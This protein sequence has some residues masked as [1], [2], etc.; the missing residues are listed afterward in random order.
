M[1]FC[2][3][4]T[5]LGTW[6]YSH[7][8]FHAV[9]LPLSAL[10]SK[11]VTVTQWVLYILIKCPPEPGPAQGIRNLLG[12]ADGPLMSTGSPLGGSDGDQSLMQICNTG[13]IAGKPTSL[14]SNSSV[15]DLTFYLLFPFLPTAILVGKEGF[16][17]D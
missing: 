13:S 7:A 3:Q 2:L 8:V 12:K 11:E 15:S 4:P 5:G 6:R 10:H 9:S 1:L 17:Q 16:P 14:T